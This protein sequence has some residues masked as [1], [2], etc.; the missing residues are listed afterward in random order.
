MIV[1]IF[2]GW[3]LDAGYLRPILLTGTCP[4]VLGIMMLSLSTQY[5]QI[6]LSQAVCTE[7][8]S[9]LLGLT[10]VAVTSLYFSSRRMIATSIAATGSSL[11]MVA[12]S[13]R[14]LAVD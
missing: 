3:L 11:G 1:G 8:G 2:T 4:E 14:F 9:G 10:S 7:L 13:R 12:H 5:W 6:L